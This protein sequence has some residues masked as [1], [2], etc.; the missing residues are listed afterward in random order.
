MSANFYINSEES[1]IKVTGSI[2]DVASLVGNALAEI[3]KGY[4]PNNRR[5]QMAVI[6]GFSY[7]ATASLFEI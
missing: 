2:E 1:T 7:A 5:E 4:S 6:S 3:A